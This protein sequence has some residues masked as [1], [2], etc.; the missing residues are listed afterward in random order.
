MVA[1]PYSPVRRKRP[2]FPAF[3]T[4]SKT[5]LFPIIFITEKQCYKKYSNNRHSGEIVIFGYARVSTSDQETTLQIDALKRAGVEKIY[6]E[7]T[8]SIGARIELR[9]LLATLKKDD[10]LIVYKLDRLARSLKDLLSILE[11]IEKSGCGFRS[12]TEPIDTVS[13]A[14]K[15]MLNILG[16]VAEFERSLIRE[17]SIAGQV[18]AIKLGRWPGRPKKL[19]PDQEF[20]LFE[21]W[22]S[23]TSKADLTRKFNV[24][25]D[26]VKMAIFRM[27]RP[28]HPRVYGNRPVLGPLLN[29]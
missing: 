6:Q 29:Q 24:S 11:Q 18:A 9:K 4:H 8:S 2:A 28:D 10:L 25:H 14:G 13:P 7:K 19:N 26:V 12:L 17:R 1:W 15:L 22:A 27:T 20:E 16:S 23:G 21:L 5:A 3:K